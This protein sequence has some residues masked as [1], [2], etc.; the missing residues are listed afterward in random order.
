MRTEGDERSTGHDEGRIFPETNARPGAIRQ[1]DRLI[2]CVALLPDDTSRGG[3]IRGYNVFRM[4][5]QRS[6]ASSRETLFGPV[7]AGS[8]PTR[9]KP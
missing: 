5:F 3:L 2:H 6:H 4:A 7:V 8:S 1:Y 9:R